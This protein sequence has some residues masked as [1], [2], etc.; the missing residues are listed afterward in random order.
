MQNYFFLFCY[1]FNIFFSAFVACLT[2]LL[3]C[4][5]SLL[6]CQR[7]TFTATLSLGLMIKSENHVRFQTQKEER[8]D[9]R[10]DI[11]RDDGRQSLTLPFIY[12]KAPTLKVIRQK[13]FSNGILKPF[14]VPQTTELIFYILTLPLYIFN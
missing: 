7:N 12:V 3:S 5:L 10:N 6:I 2:E 13:L 11:K 8:S 14:S 4:D 1:E 9:F